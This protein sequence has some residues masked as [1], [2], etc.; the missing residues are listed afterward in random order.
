MTDEEVERMLEEI[1]QEK[2]KEMEKEQERVA[3]GLTPEPGQGGAAPQQPQPTAE[4]KVNYLD[5]L[6]DRINEDHNKEV[7]ERIINK[8]SQKPKKLL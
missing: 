7:L 6:K 8:Q 1:E 4:S 2:E 3:A 5:F